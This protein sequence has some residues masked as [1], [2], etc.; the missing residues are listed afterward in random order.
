VDTP[1]LV[2]IAFRSHASKHVTERQFITLFV[3]KID[4]NLRSIVLNQRVKVV[5]KEFNLRKKVSNVYKH[6]EMILPFL[7]LQILPNEEY[8]LHLE[9]ASRIRGLILS[10]E[11]ARLWQHQN[12]L[13]KT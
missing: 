7:D 8:I 2:F 1:Q 6:R 12:H 11:R 5:F 10:I 4:R 3:D 13:Q 9:L